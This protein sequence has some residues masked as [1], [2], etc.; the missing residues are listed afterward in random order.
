M[1]K[2]DIKIENLPEIKAAF[3]KAPERMTKNLN[4]AIKKTLFNIQR[5]E[6][7]NYQALGIHIITRG[8][9][10]SIQRGL[11]TT[12]LKGEVG[13][14]VTGSPGVNYAI[15]VHEGTKYMRSRPFL[16]MA[17]ASKREETT[18][19]FKEAVQTTLDEIARS[20]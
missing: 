15:Y 13:P 18:R 16:M 20:A 1:P 9:Y 10:S 5:G 12:N 8:L 4:D 6:F 14:N 2:F 17:V 19:Y 11:Y 7:E 3:K